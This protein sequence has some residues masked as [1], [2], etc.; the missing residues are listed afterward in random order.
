MPSV[1]QRLRRLSLY[2]ASPRSGCAQVQGHRS[3]LGGTFLFLR[4][5]PL[6]FVAN[7]GTLQQ[8]SAHSCSLRWDRGHPLLLR[9]RQRRSESMTIDSNSS[10]VRRGESWLA[11]WQIK[12]V[13]IPRHAEVLCLLYLSDDVLSPF[14]PPHLAP[15]V[16]RCSAIALRLGGAIMF[17]GLPP[18]SFAASN[19]TF[20]QASA[21]SC[22]L[23]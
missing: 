10:K 12:P 5:P 9:T 1:S 14:L 16:S 19:E 3:S 8:A 4:L 18:S 20:Q 13:S 11:T 15:G 2:S 7:C 23:G 22:S 6:S 17:L 21:L